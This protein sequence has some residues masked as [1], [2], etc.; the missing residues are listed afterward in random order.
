M[1]RLGCQT[2]RFL[3]DCKH[4]ANILTLKL[5][6]FSQADQAQFGF[7]HLLPSIHYQLAITPV[8][9][10]GLGD[11]SQHFEWCRAFQVPNSLGGVSPPFL[12]LWAPISSIMPW[13]THKSIWKNLDQRETCAPLWQQRWGSIH[14]ERAQSWDTGW[15]PTVPACPSHPLEH[16]GL[17]HL[18]VLKH[19]NSHNT[20][21]PALQLHS[22]RI[23]PAQLTQGKYDKQ[24]KDN[25]FQTSHKGAS[26]T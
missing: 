24:Q 26:I 16:K 21:S 7:P 11:S 20:S 15:Q 17:S 9:S 25:W 23:T 1:K 8:L 22:P 3:N 19:K 13:P 12:Y 18:Q 10:Q 4:I 2:W 6:S 5:Q 14:R